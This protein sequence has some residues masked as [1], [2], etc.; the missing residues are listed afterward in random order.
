MPDLN[1]AQK[2]AA[3][4]AQEESQEPLKIS[5][6]E[7]Y[8]VLIRS[9]LAR[10][11]RQA[12]KEMVDEEAQI[13]RA[14]QRALNVKNRN[15]KSFFKQSRCT[16]LKGGKI[17]S[18]TGVKDYALF[19]HTY[20][21]HDQIIGCFICK[22]RWR[23][24]DTREYLVRNGRKIK[25]HTKIGWIEANEL[26]SQSSNTPSMSEIPQTFNPQEFKGGEDIGPAEAQ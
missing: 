9:L 1:E 16:H 15:E 25:N 7:Q 18:K 6:K 26:F 14:K 10:E 23:P 24:L 5:E 22:M 3:Q 20:I 19:H 13:A 8:D 4:A 21:N 2:L 12:K 17:K 11:A